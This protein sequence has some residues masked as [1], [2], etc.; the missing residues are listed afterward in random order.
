MNEW[1]PIKEAAVALGVSERTLQ[2]H[3]ATGKIDSK[4]EN[5]RRLVYVNDNDI[6]ASI[7]VAVDVQQLLNEKEALVE[8]LKSEIEHLRQVLAETQ[9]Q[10]EESSSR[11]D[12]IILQLTQQLDRAHLQLEDL[13]QRR[14]VWQR[15]RSVFVSADTANRAA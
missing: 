2:R 4:L 6:D 3:I 1:L 11:S 13:R 14:S 8:Q 15:M 9:R 12:T 5:G 10:L 7:D